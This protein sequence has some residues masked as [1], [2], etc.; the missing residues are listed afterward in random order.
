[1]SRNSLAALA[2]RPGA[3]RPSHGRWASVVASLAL[4]VAGATTIGVGA[5][6]A[7]ASTP[8]W[9]S[10]EVAAT[11]NV[12][13]YA[14]VNSVSCAST[15]S[16]V[17]GGYYTDSNGHQAFVS[18]YDGS[19]WTDTEVAKALNVGGYA[20]VISVSCAST[21]SCVAGGY[22]SDSS[23]HQAFVS[24]YDGSTWT[25]TEVAKA[26]NVG[27]D[28]SVNSVSC[29]STT[30]C[31]AGGSYVDSGGYFQAFV[32][33]YD[34]STWTDTEVAKALNV[35]AAAE[36]NS[37][38]CVSSTFCV[39]GG[40]YEDAGTIQ[41]FVS[42]YDGSTWTDTEVAKALN[43]GGG[44]NVNSVSCASTTSCVAGGYYTGS[45]SHAQAFVSVY[46]G[47]TWTDTEVAGAL[48]VGVSAGVNSVSCASTTSCVAGGY[49]SDSSG[50]QAFVS[51][52]DGST[53]TDIE[54]AGAL[55]V[56]GYA[57][58]N[59]VNCPSTTSCFAGG[60]Y[61]DSSSH[62]QAFVSTDAGARGSTAPVVEP[63][64]D[65]VA[66]AL[67]DSSAPGAFYVGDGLSATTGTW[68]FSTGAYR[69]QWYRCASASAAA[70]PTASCD[71]VAGAT[72]TTYTLSSADAGSYLVV[73]VGTTGQDGRVAYAASNA[74]GLVT[75]E[76]RF[77]AGSGLGTPPGPLAASGA[78]VTL[79]GADGLKAPYGAAFAGWSD[80][81]TTYPAGSTYVPS[82]PVTL[83]A[84]WSYA[85]FGLGVPAFAV[86]SSAVSPPMRA[87]LAALAARVRREVAG[88]AVLSL[89]QVDA[90]A[91][92]S[93]GALDARLQRARAS[94]LATLLR[95]L[96]GSS[97]G[98][99]R[100]VLSPRP[101][102]AGQRISTVA[103][104]FSA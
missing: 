46:D 94:A 27:G 58:V 37:V 79:P 21:T 35:G 14:Y 10:S 53:W 4:V 2:A 5:T 28:A 36:V 57:G 83:T 84:A 56:G 22:Y 11:L 50:H 89:V 33:V 3:R 20:S 73:T 102:Q 88:G 17:A 76:V 38:S 64:I 65:V 59:S 32:S 101:A 80:G 42:V 86:G 87:R 43:V 67:S 90:G 39:A 96:F 6:P 34:G 26:L 55:N 41:A 7:G 24:V 100:V 81:T 103:V 13:G 54:V 8:G 19:T 92:P 77:S 63:A 95:S 44:A 68:F 25:D 69:Y 98:G 49:Y 15:T 72:G 45:S 18:V 99:A 40:I 93:H 70:N 48:N 82:A 97:L 85:P 61:R 75:F 51:V 9:T 104:A 47:S 66:P 12:G 30:S 91:D 1:M 78:G 71:A 31:V 16:C 60:Y 23:G 62:Y 29:A 74:S 52:Y